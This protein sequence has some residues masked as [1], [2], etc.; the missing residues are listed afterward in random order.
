MKRLDGKV[1]IIT[2]A[3]FGMGRAAAELFAKEGAKVVAVAR[4]ADKLE[5]LAKEVSD[6]G[7]SITTL[8]LDIGEEANWTKIVETAADNYGKIDILVNNAGIIPTGNAGLEECDMEQWDRILRINTTAT[9]LGM[10]AAVPYMRKAGGGS[11]INCSSLA[12]LM[13]GAAGGSVAYSASKGAVTSMTKFAAVELAKDNIRVNS[14]HPGGIYTNIFKLAGL[15]EEE[16]KKIYGEYMPLP[17]HM[18]ESMDIAYGYLYL[19]SDES[20]F[21][22]GIELVIDGGWYAK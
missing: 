15:S 7:G 18:G 22:T 11:I 16:G 1:A 17:P 3:S 10:K 13:G 2:G 8:A 21:V 4:S 12:A 20:K 5:E 6:S 19:A 9:W 14:V